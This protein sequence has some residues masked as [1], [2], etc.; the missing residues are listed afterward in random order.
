MKIEDNI[1]IEFYTTEN[2]IC[3]HKTATSQ[4]S[5]LNLCYH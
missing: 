5:L 3:D 4:S 2:N 1:R